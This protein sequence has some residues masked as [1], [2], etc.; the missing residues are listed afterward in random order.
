MEENINKILETKDISKIYDIALKYYQGDEQTQINYNLAVELFEK[1]IELGENR[2]KFYLAESIYY[3]RGIEQ[4]YE[5]AFKMFE[6]I[7]DETNN[8]I[9]KFYIGEMY[10]HGDY[11]KVDYEKAYEI[12]N[13]LVE[14]YNDIPA[15]NYLG[16]M[17][18]YGKYV[19]QD[20][21][22]AYN[23]FSRLSEEHNYI[24]SKYFLAVMY[25]YG[26]HVDKDYE[27]AYEIFKELIENTNR[28]EAKYYIGLMYYYGNY[29]EQDYEKAY[30]IF[31]EL[32][33][34]YDDYYSKY[35]LG[36]MYYNGEFLE[37]DYEKAYEI[38]KYL[39]EKYDNDEYKK[40]LIKVLY[41]M[42]EYKEALSVFQSL[43]NQNDESG[44]I[45]YYMG[46]IHL[47]KG[48]EEKAFEYFKI[49]E[50]NNWP[51]AQ[52]EL[53]QIYLSDERKDVCKVLELCQSLIESKMWFL[54]DWAKCVIGRLYYDGKE[55]GYDIEE[56]KEKGL[57]LIKEAAEANIPQAIKFLEEIE[58]TNNS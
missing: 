37:Q 20:Y 53:I 22:K 31:N 56:D 51:L 19:E 23:I 5:K 55:Y 32:V 18:Y 21:E 17:Y 34:K 14:Q 46:E 13:E 4:S 8:A 24:H 7:I 33:E 38:F 29:K 11:V 35:Y 27:K 54:S 26:R 3:G 50:L 47:K 12:F 52:M 42:G 36:L 6:E 10:Y 30:N 41:Y 16:R 49:S 1:A 9:A 45:P 2:A 40:E 57:K 43:E 44:E 48:N 58:E 25:Y 15:E 28:W 39:V